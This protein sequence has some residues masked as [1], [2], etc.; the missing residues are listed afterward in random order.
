VEFYSICNDLKN[1]IF[2]FGFSFKTRPQLI[3]LKQN[4]DKSA[5]VVHVWLFSTGVMD[6]QT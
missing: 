2:D 1:A 3:M 4:R 5:D 6:P